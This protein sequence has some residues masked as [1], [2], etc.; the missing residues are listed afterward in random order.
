MSRLLLMI[1]TL[2]L[3]LAASKLEARTIDIELQGDNGKVLGN[4]EKF[5]DGKEGDWKPYKMFKRVFLYLRSSD[6]FLSP[7]YNIVVEGGLPYFLDAYPLGGG[8]NHLAIYIDFASG[9]T[10][11][12]RDDYRGRTYNIIVSV[13]ESASDEVTK[14][15]PYTIEDLSPSVTTNKLTVAKAE[16]LYE[17]ESLSAVGGEAPYSWSA[18]GLPSGLRI[19]TDGAGKAFIAGT[20]D[21]ASYVDSPYQVTLRV[22]DSSVGNPE[23]FHEVTLPLHVIDPLELDTTEL[24]D[25]WPGEKYSTE[26][27]ASGGTAPYAWSLA[28]T[29]PDGLEFVQRGDAAWLEGAIAED[30]SSGTYPVELTISDSGMI[31]QELTSTLALY[32]REPEPVILTGNLPLAYVGFPYSV[33]LRA[34]GVAPFTWEVRGLPAGLNVEVNPSSGATSI[35]GVP[36]TAGAYVITLTVSDSQDPP[37]QSMTKVALIVTDDNPEDSNRVAMLTTYLPEAA[38]S[39]RY[40][41]TALRASGG[42]GA[43]L[44]TASGLPAGLQLSGSG[45]AWFITG[46]I[47]DTPAVYDVLLTVADATD[48]ENASAATF[49]LLVQD[50]ADEAPQQSGEPFTNNSALLAGAAAAGCSLGATHDSATLLALLILVLS[51]FLA[52]KATFAGHETMG[53]KV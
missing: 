28:S 41:A 25:A 24:P 37:A 7:P 11:V 18:S 50:S 26:L 43:Y 6:P 49:K 19:E 20:P 48:P 2:C 33:E 27:T 13:S 40:S 45:N 47:E 29:L 38:A 5:P 34:G 21:P 14:V 42:S 22:E 31:H 10:E 8:P 17:S 23:N 44:W 46:T 1:I 9:Y 53:E 3:V 36:E 39:E 52:V 35:A 4:Q 32:V 12:P 16:H 30:F 15:F 51:V